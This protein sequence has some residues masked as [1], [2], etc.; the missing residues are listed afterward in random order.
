MNGLYIAF[1]YAG[2]A[3]GSFLPGFLYHGFGWYVYLG[4]LALVVG[5]AGSL[6]WGLRR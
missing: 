4:S 5:L 2:G 1:Y 6:L 3:I